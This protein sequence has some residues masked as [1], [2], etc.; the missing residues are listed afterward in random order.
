METGERK[1]NRLSLSSSNLFQVLSAAILPVRS[2]ASSLGT[3]GNSIADG[4]GGLLIG[5]GMNFLMSSSTQAMMSA[6]LGQ[7]IGSGAAG[8]VVTAIISFIRNAMDKK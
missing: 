7:V 4:L 6:I 2:K 8:L 5:Q 1:W 3:T